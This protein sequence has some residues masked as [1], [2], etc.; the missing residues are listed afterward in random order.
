VLADLLDTQPEQRSG[1]SWRRPE[2]GARLVEVSFYV[3]WKILIWG[4]PSETT[5]GYTI[6]RWTQTVKA[7]QQ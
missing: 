2:Y 6:L 5:R 4:T 3:G 7:W 1:P